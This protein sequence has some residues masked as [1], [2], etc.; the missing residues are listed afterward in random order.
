MTSKIQEFSK[1]Y[2]KVL[3][4]TGGF[5]TYG[6]LELLDKE[7]KIKLHKFKFYEWYFY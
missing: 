7:N 4:V 1:E 6:I 5:H 2:K 3:V